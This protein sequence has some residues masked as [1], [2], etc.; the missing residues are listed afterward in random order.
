[1]LKE[2]KQMLLEHYEQALEDLE[3]LKINLE[4]KSNNQIRKDISKI[5]VQGRNQVKAIYD[6][7]EFEEERLRKEQLQKQFNDMLNFV[8]MTR[9]QKKESNDKT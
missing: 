4:N 1:M 3:E 9:M 2:E 6:K 7:R 5:I 8:P